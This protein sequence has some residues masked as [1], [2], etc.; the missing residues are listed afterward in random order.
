MAKG[1]WEGYDDA[2]DGRDD[3][4]GDGAESRVRKSVED[5]G[6]GEDVESNYAR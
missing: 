1:S 2:N 6:S 4:E 5:L 3:V